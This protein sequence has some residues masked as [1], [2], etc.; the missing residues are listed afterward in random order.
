MWCLHRQ[1]HDQNIQKFV[2]KFPFI[3]TSNRLIPLSDSAFYASSLSSFLSFLFFR[4]LFCDTET[5]FLHDNCIVY[6]NFHFSWTAFAVNSIR[7]VLVILLSS[8][9]K[10]MSLV[11]PLSV[12]IFMKSGNILRWYRRP[13]HCGLP[14][15]KSRQFVVCNH[16][17]HG[18]VAKGFVWGCAGSC[19]RFQRIL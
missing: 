7:P 17:L 10:I 8:C 5:N 6:A 15:T 18:T 19:C 16:K 12:L 9:H 2:S 11:W 1:C 14:V 3:P 13:L 4:V